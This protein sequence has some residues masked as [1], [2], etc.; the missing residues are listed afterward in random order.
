METFKLIIRKLIYSEGIVFDLAKWLIF[1][2]LVFLVVNTFFVA[3]FV[4]DGMSMDP[5]YQ[6]GELV[7]WS[8]TAYMKGNPARG[9]VVA[10]N[11][12]GDPTRKKYVKRVVGLPNERVDIF[13]GK[14]Y[15]NK[16]LFVENYIGADIITEP[17]GTWTMKDN[18]YFVMGDNRPNSNDSRYFGPVEKRFILGPTIAI[19][20]PRFRLAGDI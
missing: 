1:A 19:V 16:Q 2:L 15:I 13:N 14:V 12:P 18:E 5:N 9:D 17:N 10:V 8:K 3:F 11:Y 4:V 20:F 7:L 6:N